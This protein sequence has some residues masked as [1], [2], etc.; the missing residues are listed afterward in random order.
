MTHYEK[1]FGHPMPTQMI[2]SYDVLTVG[3]IQD[4]VFD[5]SSEEKKKFFEQ[6]RLEG[7]EKQPIGLCYD[8]VLFRRPNYF[9]AQ[10]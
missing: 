6:L 2:E 4:Y 1:L 3:E 9:E 5:M 8:D 7:W 10:E